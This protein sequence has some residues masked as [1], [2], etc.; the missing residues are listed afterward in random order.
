MEYFEL[1]C[2]KPLPDGQEDKI[3]VETFMCMSY[4]QEQVKN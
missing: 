1:F 2:L 4:E 3:K